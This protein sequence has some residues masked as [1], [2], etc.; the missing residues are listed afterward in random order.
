VTYR[1]D[2]DVLVPPE[3]CQR[4]ISEDSDPDR[5]QAVV[6]PL[7]TWAIEG[8]QRAPGG[9]GDV[10]ELA[11]RLRGGYLQS[12]TK[13]PRFIVMG[14]PTAPQEDADTEA[15]RQDRRRIA[16]SLGIDLDRV[17]ET[18][19]VMIGPQ[20]KPHVI[21]GQIDILFAEGILTPATYI[22]MY[23]HYLGRKP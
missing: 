15:E 23:Q 1:D 7:E 19:E 18:N 12:T 8:E 11:S 20:H 17:R 21:Q 16:R 10:A 5:A 2:S 3:S 13:A 9:W 4:L 6:E 14:L 22:N